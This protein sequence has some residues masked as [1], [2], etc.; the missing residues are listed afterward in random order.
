[1]Q[2][3]ES[4][5]ATGH[6]HIALHKADGTEQHFDFKNLVVDAGLVWII[7]RMKDAS[8]AVMSHMAI[9]SGATSPAAGNTTLNTELGRVALSSTTQSSKTLTFVA[10]FNAG[11]GTG[12]IT[13]AGDRK[14][15]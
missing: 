4:I 13:E 14:S 2:L 7:S 9:G 3:T 11:T 6:L 12:A 15:T 10:T 8:S 5:K 1:M